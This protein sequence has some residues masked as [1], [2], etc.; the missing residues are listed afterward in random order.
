MT[1]AIERIR[2][3]SLPRRSTL[4]PITSR[5]ESGR[6]TCVER[7]LG[8]PPSLGVLTDSARLDRLRS[9]SLTKNGLPSVS[10]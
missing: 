6:A 1:A 9:T 8:H 7:V 5:T 2:P 4:A 3:A 10:R